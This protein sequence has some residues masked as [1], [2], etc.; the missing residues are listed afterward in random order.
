MSTKTK[1]TQKNEDEIQV[2]ATT[3]A[4][5]PENNVDVIPAVLTFPAAVP[6]SNESHRDEET[7]NPNTME[8]AIKK[9]AVAAENGLNLR[10]GPGLDVLQ[11]LPDGAE[12]QMVEIPEDAAIEGWCPVI[13]GD[14][15]RGWVMDQYIQPLEG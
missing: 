6:E 1:K 7:T 4:A 3:P 10:R 13:A 15:S 8:P 14:G 9:A 11:I 12:L 2:A 5:T